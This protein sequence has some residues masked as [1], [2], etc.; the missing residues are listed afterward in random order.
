MLLL[1]FHSTA[2][3]WFLIFYKNEPIVRVIA[4]LNQSAQAETMLVLP[5]LPIN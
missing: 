2:Q 4:S 3:P 5:L 1:T